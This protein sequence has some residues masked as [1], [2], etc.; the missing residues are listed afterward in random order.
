VEVGRVGIALPG[1]QRVELLL[2]AHLQANDD[3][4]RGI[5]IAVADQGGLT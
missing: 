5:C 2:V 3:L 4:H 1:D